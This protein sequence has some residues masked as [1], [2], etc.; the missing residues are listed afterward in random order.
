[1]PYAERGST[2]GRKKNG[3]CANGNAKAGENRSVFVDEDLF[4]VPPDLAGHA[5]IIR[6][7]L[8]IDPERLGIST[9]SLDVDLP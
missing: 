9:P 4:E 6:V 7:L 3:I 5:A 8:E 2:I 1:M